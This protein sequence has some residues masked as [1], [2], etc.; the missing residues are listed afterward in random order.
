MEGGGRVTFIDT[1]NPEA[2][3]SSDEQLPGAMRVPLNDLDTMLAPI[4]KDGTVV[5]YCT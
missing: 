1:R 4:P 5:T 2:W 3:A